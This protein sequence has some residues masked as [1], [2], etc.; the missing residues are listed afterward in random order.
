MTSNLPLSKQAL[1]SLYDRDYYRW[2]KETVSLLK[3]GDLHEL[4]LDNLIEEIAE[5]GRREKRAVYSNLKIVLSHLLKYRYQ[6]ER[7]SNS[8]RS[9][10]VEHRQRLHRLFR[11]SPS[12]KRYTEEIFEESY[13][14][15][16]A[17]AAAETGLSKAIFPENSPFS[18]QETLDLEYL[19]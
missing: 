7:T 15:A 16:I 11:E 3:T 8:W 18:M 12:L 19:P 2:L 4:D 17:L 6:P 1:V 14:D 5:M 9:T 10:L 13:R